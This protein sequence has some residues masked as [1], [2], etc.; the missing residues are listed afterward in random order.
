MDGIDEVIIAL[1][2]S[3]LST[4]GIH[5]ELKEIYGAEVSSMLIS[6]VTHSVLEDV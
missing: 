5:E 3:R 2:A 6:N 4:C 1:Y